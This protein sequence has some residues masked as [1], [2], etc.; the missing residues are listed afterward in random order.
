ADVEPPRAHAQRARREEVPRLVDEDEQG[1]PEDGDGEIHQTIAVFRSASRR[2][3]ASASTRSA[4][5]RAGSPFTAPSASSTV[6][7]I[8]RNGSR[9]SRNAPTATSLAAL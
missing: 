7:A 9:P 6:S 8:P 1:E 3:C 2:A 4:R 5:S